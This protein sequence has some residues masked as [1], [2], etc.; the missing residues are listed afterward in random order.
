MLTHFNSITTVISSDGSQVDFSELVSKHQY[1][2]FYFSAHWC[3]PCRQFTPKLAEIYKS[4]KAKDKDLEIIFVSND[5][6]EE[7]FK[8]YVLYKC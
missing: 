5:K 2:G 3:G 1:F 6:D 4:Y 7:S 8:E